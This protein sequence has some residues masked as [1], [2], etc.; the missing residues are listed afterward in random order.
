MCCNCTPRTEA[1]SSTPRAPFLIVFD[2]LLL[3]YAGADPP[4]LQLI[5]FNVD[6]GNTERGGLFELNWRF[7]TLTCDWTVLDLWAVIGPVRPSP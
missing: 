6:A 2:P 7:G 1:E 3:I 5:L 4:K